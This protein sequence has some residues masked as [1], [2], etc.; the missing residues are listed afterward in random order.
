MKKTLG[1]GLIFVALATGVILLFIF[2][3]HS[4]LTLNPKNKFDI[5]GKIAILNSGRS[6]WEKYSV[7]EYDWRVWKKQWEASGGGLVKMD[8][9]D[10]FKESLNQNPQVWLLMLDEGNKAIWYR[11]SSA[12]VVYLHY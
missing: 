6:S 10:D 8:N 1:Y 12:I 9:W 4:Q 3:S 11:P 5:H 7:K 2:F